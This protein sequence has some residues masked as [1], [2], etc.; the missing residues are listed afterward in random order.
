MPALIFSPS[1]RQ[2][3]IEI[4][5]YIAADDP[6]AAGEWIDKIEEKCELIATTPKLGERRPEFGTEVRSSLTGRYVIFYR[7]IQAGIEVLRVIAGD[8]DTQSL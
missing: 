8:R 2:D 3:L 4:F 5:D 1:A 6:I 7:Q